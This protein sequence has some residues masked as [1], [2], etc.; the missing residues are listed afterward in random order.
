MKR[1]SKVIKKYIKIWKQIS[2]DDDLKELSKCDV[3]IFSGYGG[4]TSLSG[5]FYWPWIDPIRERLEKEGFRC[6]SI[7]LPFGIDTKKNTYFSYLSMNRSYLCALIIDKLH[8]I[9]YKKE[10][11]AKLNLFKKIISNAQPRLI[12][13]VSSQPMLALAARELDVFSVELLHG[14]GYTPVPWGW[15][16]A[17]TKH[18][19]QGILSLDRVSTNTFSLLAH[20]GIKTY[21]LAHPFLCKFKQE[22]LHQIPKEW[23]PNNVRMSKFKKQVLV[24]LQW[25]YTPNLDCCLE[26][27]GI[28]K[29]GL[30]PQELEKII[31]KTTEKIL[32]RFRFHP[33]HI[34]NPKKYKVHFDLIKLLASKYPNIEWQESTSLPLPAVLDICDAVVT[35]SSMVSYE[36]AYMG[37]PTLAL[38]PTLGPGKHNEF[39]L[40]DLVEAGYVTKST[41]SEIDILEWINSSKK[42]RSFLSNL[43]KE[44]ELWEEAKK[45]MLNL[46]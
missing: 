45:W 21:E 26:F 15:D 20:E 46:P 23:L 33:T 7:C 2:F 24:S 16:S 44:D 38:C 4:G 5:K 31:S 30:F 37:K 19:P 27:E 6:L 43:D 14:I 42:I 32:W 34:G 17:K 1:V 28:L 11:R 41:A 25:G 12:V 22:N 10:G 9:F 8:R 36:A 40:N 35:M 18:L 39:F 3:L 29:N 13:T